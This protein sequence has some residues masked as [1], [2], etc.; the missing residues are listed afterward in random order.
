MT[1]M[2]T[3]KTMDQKFSWSFFGFILAVILGALS[4][5]LS[6]FKNNNPDI[7]Y[8]ITTNSSVLDIKEEIGNLDVLY[9]GNSLSKER[10]DLRII[11]FKV[12]N[13]GDS[14]VIPSL[15]DP[16]DPLGFNV[17]NGDIAEKPSL[18]S[19]S[20]KYLE[21]KLLITQNKN[22]V[23]FS[24]VILE[25]NEYFEIKLLVLHPVGTK[26]EIQSVGKIAGVHAIN[27][28]TGENAVDERSFF[29]AT[30][31]G[32]VMKNI[33]RTLAYGILF[34]LLII[35]MLFIMSSVED[36]RDKSKRKSIV[37]TFKEY[38]GEKI[39]E[40]DD[41]FFDL[42]VDGH[43][44]SLT[45]AY[46]KIKNPAKKMH[47]EFYLSRERKGRSRTS[48]EQEI[49]SALIGRGFLSQEHDELFTSNDRLLVIEEFINFLRRKGEYSDYLFKKRQEMMVEYDDL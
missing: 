41:Y 42:Y 14:S 10:K 48:I 43:R 4:I 3:L 38:D 34:L 44:G 7:S 27:V 31:G 39:T 45:Y 28:V 24:N 30:F 11:T 49:I 15:Y 33:A 32:G 5:Y 26:P 46:E 13:T 20:N 6:F 22:S 21:E 40:S 23:L 19:A 9:Q 29:N 18:I 17:V 1:I 12:V 37:K 47:V 36:L 35:F 2:N 25:N 8:V 16:T